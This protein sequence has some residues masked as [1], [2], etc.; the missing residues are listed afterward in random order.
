[1]LTRDTVLRRVLA[2]MRSQAGGGWRPESPKA[3]RTAN[4]Y[5]WS[6]ADD[7]LRIA[8]NAGR[9]GDRSG[10]LQIT[11]K[12]HTGWATILYAEIGAWQQPISLLAAYWLID[13][14]HT[15]AFLRGRR[16]ARDEV[17]RVPR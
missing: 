10:Y 9:P 4:T 7:R 5:M 6:S 2:E 3:R 14:K 17:R 8:V 11:Q 15:A 13:A 12:F 1:M 16:E